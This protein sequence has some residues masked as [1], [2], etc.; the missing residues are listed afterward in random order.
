MKLLVAVD[1]VCVVLKL[2]EKLLFGMFTSVFLLSSV[3]EKGVGLRGVH[4]EEREDEES[5]HIGWWDVGTKKPARLER[6]IRAGV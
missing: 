5:F 3:V 6:D 1:E 4:N 2:V